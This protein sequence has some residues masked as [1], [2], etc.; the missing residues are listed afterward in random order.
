MPDIILSEIESMALKIKE[1]ALLLVCHI[2]E[3]LKYLKPENGYGMKIT[4]GKL[5]VEYA[6]DYTIP[7]AII[8]HWFGDYKIREDYRK[9]HPLTPAPCY[10]KSTKS[11]TLDVDYIDDWFDVT[12]ACFRIGEAFCDAYLEYMRL[13]LNKRDFKDF[14]SAFLNE[15][16]PHEVYGTNSDP[17]E[18]GSVKPLTEN[19]IRLY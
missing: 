15:M 7:M 18:Y 2:Y 16:F 13:K 12:D 1:K 3:S 6:P 11:V 14:E 9:T 10:N 17:Y 19:K 8:V 4:E 5:T